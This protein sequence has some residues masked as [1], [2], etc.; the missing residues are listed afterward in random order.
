MMSTQIPQNYEQWKHC[1]TVECGIPLTLSF[2]SQR[3]KSW[4][5]ESSEETQR[6]RRLYGDGHWQSVISWFERAENDLRTGARR[7]D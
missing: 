6:F 1:I 4:R 2:V 5:H 3:L 7:Q